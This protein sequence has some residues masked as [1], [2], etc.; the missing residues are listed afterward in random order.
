MLKKYSI[1]IFLIVFSVAVSAQ[2]QL[3]WEDLAD[4]NFRPVYNARY[5]TNFLM[6]TFG[7]AIAL[8]HGKKVSIQGYF[9][10]ITRNGDI[11]LLS[12]NP[13]ASC[14]FCGGAGPETVIEVN[15]EK[16]PTFRTDQVVK[17]MGVLELNVDDVDHCNYIL[18][19][20]T[21]YLVN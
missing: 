11:Y 9:L 4:V 15:F 6:P 2:D 14:F 19:Q 17:V 8:Y 3:S 7:N 20:A 12:R 18:T 5:D 10:D 16:R 1:L 21:G 13:M